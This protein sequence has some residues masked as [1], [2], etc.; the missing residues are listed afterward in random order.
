MAFASGFWKR[1]RRTIWLNADMPC[2]KIGT[3]HETPS[4]SSQDGRDKGL[5]ILN[6]GVALEKLDF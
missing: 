5:L 6:E 4:G 2:V 3:R 1:S